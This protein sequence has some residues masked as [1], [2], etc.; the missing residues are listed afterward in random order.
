ME[1]H[2]PAH[3]NLQIPNYHP[4]SSAS[5]VRKQSTDEMSEGTSSSSGFKSD[6]NSGTIFTLFILICKAAKLDLN[7]FR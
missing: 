6:Q 7:F 5:A 4:A 1:Q 2:N 3:E